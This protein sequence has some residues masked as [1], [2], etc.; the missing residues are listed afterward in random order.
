MNVPWTQ[1]PSLSLREV[2]KLTGDTLAGVEEKVRDGRLPGPE[3]GLIW[4]SSVVEVYSEPSREGARSLLSTR[5]G[6]RA[7]DRARTIEETG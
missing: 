5:L 6:R 3:P 4:P 2:Q 7:R 1:R